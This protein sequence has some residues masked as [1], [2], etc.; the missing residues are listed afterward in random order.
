M[1]RYM[2]MFI[3]S[4]EA[5]E[6]QPKEALQRA[7]AEVNT[8]WA[9]HSGSGKIVGGEELQPARTATTIR[10]ADGKILVTDGPFTEAKERIGGYA[11]V[12]VRDLDE[13]IALAKT[14]PPKSTIEVRP[15]VEH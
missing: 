4:D 5:W 12:N 14:W 3:G 2:L 7:Y 8:W 13:A 15:L 9:E 10:H 6:G 1:P 11:I